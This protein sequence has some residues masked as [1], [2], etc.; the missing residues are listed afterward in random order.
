[1]LEIDDCPVVDPGATP[2]QLHKR[3]GELYDRGVVLYEQGDYP[4]AVREFVSAYCTS[5]ALKGEANPFYTLLRNI[6]QAYE[7]NLDYEKAIAYF[8]RFVRELPA[9]AAAEKRLHESRISVL[10]KLRAQILV[11][12]LPGNANVTIFNEGGVAGLGR[13]GKRIDVPGGAYTMLV[14]LAGH[15]PHTQ[16]IEV[17]IGKP[18]AFFVPLRPLRGRLSAQLTPADAR[19]FLRDRS[20][21]RFAGV[22]RVDEVLPVGKYVLIA[23]AP[24]RLKVERPIEVLP[25]RVNRMQIDLPLKPQFGRRQLILFSAIGGAY[26]AGGLLTAFSAT[27]ISGLGVA[28]GAAIGL[29][30]SLLYLPDEVPLGASNLA[31]TAGLTGTVAGITGALVF[32][33]SER[34][35]G[36]VLGATTLLGT[37][38]GYYLGERTKISPGDAALFNSSVLWGTVAGGLFALSFGGEDR[39]IS[40][41][42]VLSG[43]GMGAVSGV[44]MTRYFEVSRRRAVLIDIG[45][46]AGIIGGLAA[47]G[48]VYRSEEDSAEASAEHVANFMLGGVA[49]GLIGAGILTRNLDAPKVPVKPA[50]GTATAAN[51]ASTMLYGVAGAW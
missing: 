1:M 16:Q 2:E 3:G 19:V 40:S 22:G 34:I 50:I 21:E 49:L 14:E 35:T 48:L 17:R 38:L 5:R 31:I 10:Q 20:V 45:G 41:G 47:E 11:E 39:R 26:S 18:F 7:R 13:S 30:G 25:D 51:G 43:L 4:G 6:G 24:D 36:P 32:T 29:L 37:G 23:E 33:S 27:E 12:T 46:I 42:L 8:E 44:L 28:G 9:S 15:E